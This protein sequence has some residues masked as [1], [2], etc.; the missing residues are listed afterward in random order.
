MENLSNSTMPIN[1]ISY[2]SSNAPSYQFA[3]NSYRR[4]GI[5]GIESDEYAASYSSVMI[6]IQYGLEAYN[7]LIKR[8]LR[9][10]F[11]LQSHGKRNYQIIP[12]G[13][14]KNNELRNTENSFTI[15]C[16]AVMPQKLVNELMEIT[17]SESSDVP[18][19][20]PAL[21]PTPDNR[22]LKGRVN[23]FEGSSLLVIIGKKGEVQLEQSLK[24]SMK[25][26]VKKRVLFVELGEEEV[27]W[28]L[29]GKFPECPLFADETDELEN[30]E[31]ITIYTQE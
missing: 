2:L 17:S 21:F 18:A 5:G 16:G 4:L 6:Y 23:K 29:C 28:Y 11:R 9:G 12:A 7:E 19:I 20:I 1:V 13:F 30:D 26:A 27:N 15:T 31:E 3:E 14:G 8:V 24:A 10:I 25:R 22:K